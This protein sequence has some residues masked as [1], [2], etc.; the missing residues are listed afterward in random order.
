M[1]L[2]TELKRRN[3]IRMAGLYLVGAWLITQVAGTV[4]PMFGA[5]EWVA[6]SVV[7]L[8]AIG[9]IPAVVFSWLY[10][11]T[12]EGLQRDADVDSAHSIAPQTARRMDRLIFAGL[13]ALIALI[14]AD[15]Y[16]PQTDPAASST[17]IAV[18]PS[19]D[20]AGPAATGIAPDGQSNVTVG[21]ADEPEVKAIVRGIAVLPFDNLSPDPDNAFFAGGIYE[22]VLTKLSR[23]GELR[24]ISRTSMEQIAKQDLQ[25]GA[26]GARLGVSHVLEGSVRRAGDQIRVTV[27]LIE[28]ASD[29]HIWAENYDR[30]LDD[31]FAI[32]SEIAIAI[33]DQLKLSLSPELQANLNERPTQNQAAYALYLRALDERRTWRGFKGFKAVIDLLEPAVAADPAFLQARV[34]LAE[35]Y[36]R[37]NWIAADPDGSYAGKARQAVA[38]ILERWPDHPQSRVA[39]GQLLYNLER[40]YA[41]ALAQFDAAREQLPNDKEL[42]LSIG[43]SLKRLNR[44]AAFL[45]AA[46]R[47]MEL[48]PEGLA[49]STELVEALMRNQRL[50]EAVTTAERAYARFPQERAVRGSLAWAKLARDGD[51]KALLELVPDSTMG[52]IA[53]F[54][55]GDLNALQR[56]PDPSVARDLGEQLAVGLLQPELLR[57]A[58]NDAAAQGFLAPFALAM[59]EALARLEGTNMSAYDR[60]FTH[61]IV[62]NWAAMAGK[63]A[64]AREHL[65]Q[66]LA[67]P[68]SDNRP[69]FYRFLS[70]TERNLGNAEAAWLLIEP[71]V[72]SGQVGGISHGE[73]RGFKP[74]YDKVYGESPSYRAYVAKIASEKK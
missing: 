29:G 56:P 70:A 19:R 55:Q 74:F 72:G 40:D 37:M 50:D 65:A 12:P 17:P 62:A 27:Q 1:N 9:F 33:A 25:V 64:Q 32:Q 59:P 54:V 68:A 67:A 63:P 13:L 28:A 43:A 26:I 38:E 34:L 52:L 21:P 20:P 57:L 23:I 35:A 36:G 22:E 4:L 45:E 48:D 11:L 73:L 60:S 47:M 14:A 24:V 44:D 58:G 10:E 18:A 51:V 66:A 16:W 7:I 41:G 69:D 15:R 39:Q 5:P 53:Y 42:Q 71:Y 46:R 61:A 3:V 6:R 30:K 2:F 31:V 8:L 49:S